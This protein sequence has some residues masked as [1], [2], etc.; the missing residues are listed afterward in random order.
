MQRLSCA[1]AHFDVSTGVEG[2]QYMCSS[3][4]TAGETAKASASGEL[5][6]AARPRVA[7][8]AVVEKRDGH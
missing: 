7:S 4:V 5:P 3:V 6:G 2:V 1:I 8:R